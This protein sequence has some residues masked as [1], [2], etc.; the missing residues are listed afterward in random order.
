MNPLEVL[1]A[2]DVMGVDDG[3][4]TQG[5]TTAETPVRALM[6]RLRGADAAIAVMEEGTQIGTVTA[7]SIV[8][9]LKA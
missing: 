2:R 9:R 7:H 5:E 8:D 3:A 6:E 1:T 4:P